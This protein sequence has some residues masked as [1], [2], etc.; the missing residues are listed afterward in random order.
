[1]KRAARQTQL[2]RSLAAILLDEINHITRRPHFFR[3]SIFN[4]KAK[5][6]LERYDEFDAVEAHAS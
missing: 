6:L 5:C 4:R 3:H 2:L 1:M